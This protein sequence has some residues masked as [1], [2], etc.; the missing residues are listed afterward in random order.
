[1]RGARGG[2]AQMGGEDVRI[3]RIQDGRLHG[4][5]EQRL[6]MVDEEGVQRVV[7]GHQDGQ[8]ALAG[9]PGAARLLPQRRSGTGVAGDDD[10]IQAGDVDAEFEGGGGG[11]SEQFPGMQGALQGPA[12]LGEVAPAVGGDPGR[13]RAVHLGEA[14][15]RDDGDQLGATPG[16]HEGD[17][18][19]ALDGEIGEEVGG[20]GGGGAADGGALLAVQ[21]GQGGSHSAKTSSPR[22]EESSATSLT[23]RPVR[24]PA[25]TEGSAAVAEARRKTGSAP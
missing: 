17:R 3:V 18:A 13:Q 10:G 9:A 12:F 7:A 23:G 1:M 8:G 4:L 19:D 25:A 2:G 15:L 14:F 21:F 16:T 24:R 22:G 11:Q 6:G 5:L 20:L